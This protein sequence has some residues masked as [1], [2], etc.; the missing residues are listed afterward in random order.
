MGRWICWVLGLICFAVCACLNVAP[1]A[2]AADLKGEIKV[3]GSSTVYLITEAVASAFKKEHPS[4]KITVGISGTGGGFK[5]FAAG[6][7]DISDASRPIKPGEIEAC[8]KNGVEFIELQAAWDG[9][10]VVIHPEN[11]WARKMTVAQLKK[12]WAPDSK[13]KRWSDVDPTWPAEPIKLFGAGPDSG[14]FDF[15]CEAING[16][17]KAHRKDY[18]PSEDDN[19]TVS[20]VAGNKYAMGYFGLAYYEENKDKLAVVAIAAKGGGPHFAPSEKT[21]LNKTYSPLGRPL[22]IYVKKSSLKRPEVQEFVRFFLRR[23][24]LVTEAKYIKTGTRVRNEQLDKLEA[25]T[26]DLGN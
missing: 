22:F 15:F 11:T 20:G 2:R 10:S 13:V 3:D 24:D 8:Q 25:A 7:T 26:K 16:K 23:T 5:K 17:E 9:L 19:V 18:T 6:E 12:I 21:V 1:V 14:T 4:V